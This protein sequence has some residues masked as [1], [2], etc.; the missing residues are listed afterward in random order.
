MS[1]KTLQEFSQDS[2]AFEQRIGRSDEEQGDAQAASPIEE[3]I[4]WLR[5]CV[6]HGRYLP[7]LSPEREALQALVDYWTTRLLRLGR[8]LPSDVE[9]LADFDPSAGVPLVVD[10]PYP[11]LE[12][13]TD[14]QRASF[15]GREAL[16]SGC[17]A[18]LEDPTKRIL[19]I[20]GGSGSGKSSLALAGV[21]PRLVERHK[22]EWLF[23]P[24]LTP[25][26]HPL[27]SLA[28]G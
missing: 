8:A 3:L 26:D 14:K 27:A 10:C 9:R 19:I 20:I 22:G 24:R 11:G 4:S 28:A 13:Y 23:A 2:N 15:F 7:A 5:T 18:H 12:P 16:V 17:I 25:G 6:T 21:L 1:L